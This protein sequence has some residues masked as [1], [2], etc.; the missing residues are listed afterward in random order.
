M[1]STVDRTDADMTG[2][3]PG[4]RVNCPDQRSGGIGLTTDSAEFPDLWRATARK[5][6]LF[7]RRSGASCELADDLVQDVAVRLLR[8]EVN[9][10]TAPELLRWSYV[11]ARR[12][13]IDHL[14]RSDAL[15]CDPAALP[16]TAAD[17]DV[18]RT[19]EARLDLAHVGRLL[20]S[21][22][23]ADRESLLQL[24]QDEAEAPPQS[25]RESTRLAVQRHRARHRLQKLIAATAALISWIVARLQRVGA[26]ASVAAAL[27]LPMLVL[28]PLPHGDGGG[29]MPAIRPQPVL[30]DLITAKMSRPR[31][32]SLG[33][34]SPRPPATHRPSATRVAT[35]SRADLRLETPVPNL[36][37]RTGTTPNAEHHLLCAGIGAPADDVCVDLPRPT[38]LDVP[39][40]TRTP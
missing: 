29:H 32:A 25:R 13:H 10:Y 22:T 21:M 14:R 40:V 4:S 34:T 23:T 12:L 37:A 9:L 24:V 16:H 5:V 18:A 27:V 38:G 28:V 20:S 31:A 15:A 26:S 35:Q 30:V 8:S 33:A 17:T 36:R 19:V 39:A 7:L 6:A 3:L 1:Q 2:G 11:V